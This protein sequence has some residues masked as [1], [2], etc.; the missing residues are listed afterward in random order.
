LIVSEA[1][2]THGVPYR[3]RAHR[4]E[5]ESHD[6]FKSALG[7][8]FV[9]RREVPD[10]S[11]DGEVEEFDAEGRATGLRYYVQVKATDE[12]ELR[13]AL[14]V[15]IPLDTANHYRDLPL[16]VLMVRYHAPRR[17]LYARWFHQFDPYY[18][19]VGARSL[20]FRWPKDSLV[21]SESPAQLADQARAF[22][23]LR[24]PSLG[25]PLPL[26]LETDSG[27]AFGLSALELLYALRDATERC[28]DVFVLQ[29]AHAGTGTVRIVARPSLLSINLANVST[30][31]AHLSEYDAGS[32]GRR[33]AVDAMVIAALAFEHMGHADLASRLA[34]AFLPESSLVGAPEVAW[35]LASALAR[36]RRIHEALAISEALDVRDDDDDAATASMLFTLPAMQGQ[37]NDSEYQAVERTLVARV[38]RR[39]TDNREVEA[40]RCS[41]NLGNFYRANRQSAS[42]LAAYDDAARGDPGYLDRS[43][44]WHERGGVL[45]GSERYTEAAE[46]YAHAS[47]LGGDPLAAALEADALMFSGQYEAAR[48]RFVAYNATN[49]QGGEEWRLKELFL[50]VL[51]DDLGIGRQ[52]RDA[53]RVETLGSAFDYAQAPAQ[54]A[55]K[56]RCALDTDA[57][58]GWAWFNLGRAHLDLNRHD[59]AFIDYLAT[60]LCQPGD[61]EAW[62]NAFVLSLDHR[63]DRAEDI[64][65]AAARLVGGPFRTQLLT[66]VRE[67]PETFPKDDFLRRVDEAMEEHAEDPQ[68]GFTLR[69]LH[70]D[71]AV[72]QVHLGPEPERP[73]EA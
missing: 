54:I 63:L 17:K 10:Y 24:S 70:S 7:E 62:V 18:G 37:L 25:L 13:K 45:F 61:A 32:Y 2:Y 55:K 73:A 57:L 30:A 8:R 12:P 60:A 40:A 56:L 46:A 69:F 48:D 72:Q 39:A 47:A 42:A 51:V 34:T 44:F 1:R 23:A 71:G 14:R 49:S 26:H 11:I 36:S 27:G 9:Y 65:A 6:A 15:S 22:F 43:Y 66:W 4:I 5:D 28:P 59:L 29:S 53:E 64:L 41:Y 3:P 67:Q 35:G 50:G 58:S 52:R 33:F 68:E 31:T 21:A 19:G 38:A 20:T 16:P